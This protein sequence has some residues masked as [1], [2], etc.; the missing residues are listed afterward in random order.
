[1]CERWNNGG[2]FGGHW[3]QTKEK[4]KTRK[5]KKERL[6][7]LLFS[8]YFFEGRSLVKE[9]ETFMASIG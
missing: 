5:K 7:F 4:K 6:F 1:M 8:N 2:H 3:P 9:R